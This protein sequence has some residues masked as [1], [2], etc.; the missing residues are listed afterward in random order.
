MN[1]FCAKTTV[2]CT[3]INPAGFKATGHNL[4][5]NPQSVCPRED[6]EGYEKCKTICKQKGHAEEV[7]I[8]L[9]AGRFEIEGSTAYIE[10]HSYFCMDCQHKL[11]SA[12]VKFLCVGEPPN[13]RG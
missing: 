11:F 2:Y 8:D 12:G 9:A 1:N 10:G 7:A 5:E 3:I 4:C 6:G 13:G